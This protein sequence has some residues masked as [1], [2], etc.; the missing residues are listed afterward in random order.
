MANLI[1]TEEFA[2][3]RNISQKM[4]SEKIE[5]CI[6]LAQQSDLV[7]M[8][9]D[10]YFDVL[11][12]ADDASYSDLMEGSEFEYCGDDFQHAGIKRLLADYTYSRYIYMLNVN[13][14]PFGAVTKYM[15]ESEKVERNTMRDLSKQAQADAGN[16]FRFIEKYI[17]SEPTLFDRYCR[18]KKQ[19]TNFSQTKFSVL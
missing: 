14:T 6:S 16:K 15:E 7:Q 12:N 3:Y 2:E 4:D 5:E 1:T 18:N 10:F 8:L 19:G 11:R 9:G 13:I 17:L